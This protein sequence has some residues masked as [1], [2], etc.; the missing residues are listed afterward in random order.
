MSVFLLAFYNASSF[1]LMQSMYKHH[2]FEFRNHMK[3]MLI[4]F[5][6]TEIAVIVELWQLFY[7]FYYN[8]CDAEKIK[9]NEAV[10]TEG[11]QGLCNY[12]YKDLG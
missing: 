8:F 3:P 1:S 7:V 11:E 2:R 10:F 9:G 6:A 4:L 12:F 5:I